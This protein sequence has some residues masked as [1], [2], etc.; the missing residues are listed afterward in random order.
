MYLIYTQFPA[1]ASACLLKIGI[2][3]NILW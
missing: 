3:G 2:Y 1:F